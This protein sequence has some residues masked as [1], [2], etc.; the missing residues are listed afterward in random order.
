[1][2]REEGGH[3]T[4]SRAVKVQILRFAIDAAGSA[5]SSADRE[6]VS[7]PSRQ[8]RLRRRSLAFLPTSQCVRRAFEAASLHAGNI[9]SSDGSRWNRGARSDRS[10]HT[11]K[12]NIVPC[13]I[14]HTLRAFLGARGINEGTTRDCCF[15]YPHQRL[16]FPGRHRRR[17]CRRSF[18]LGRRLRQASPEAD[19]GRG[20]ILGL[21]RACPRMAHHSGYA[22]T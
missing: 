9:F 7:S 2:P 8:V 20:I 13:E 10:V 17:H 19:L 15:S 3:R 5:L 18:G 22:V 14:G 4:R 12:K 1:M 11:D 6:S 21:S 16:H